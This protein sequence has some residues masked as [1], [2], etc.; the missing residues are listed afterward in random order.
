MTRYLPVSPSQIGSLRW[1]RYKRLDHAAKDTFVPLVIEEIPRVYSSMPIAFVQSDQGFVPALV[2]G[3]SPQR[4]LYVIKG[5]WL[6]SYVPALYR[7]YPFGVG[8]TNDQQLVLA[9]DMESGLVEEGGDLPFFTDDG[10]LS[11]EVEQVAQFLQQVEQNRVTTRKVCDALAAE[12]LIQP[13]AV[14]VSTDQGEKTVEGLHRIDEARLNALG[15]DA[16]H[17]VHAAGALPVAYCQLLSMKNIQNLGFIAR[18]LEEMRVSAPDA[19]TEVDLDG[20]FR[21]NATDLGVPGPGDGAAS[22]IDLSFDD[23]D[24]DLTRLSRN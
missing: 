13:W 1:S 16:L 9:V 5:H 3:L 8:K 20:F 10:S 14:K 19:G 18:K 12:G 15:A 6:G 24:I 2:S 22:V 7:G 11:P 21:R 17:R 23:G 4:N